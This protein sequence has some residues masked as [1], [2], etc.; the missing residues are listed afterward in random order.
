MRR[1]MEYSKEKTSK[2]GKPFNQND[3]NRFLNDICGEVPDPF[4]TG[5]RMAVQKNIITNENQGC[6]ER[7][8]NKYFVK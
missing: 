8:Q 2:K 4:V 3:F 5:F 6:S 1:S 7:G